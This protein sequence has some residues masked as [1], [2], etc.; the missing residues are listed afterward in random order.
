MTHMNAS[1]FDSID[2]VGFCCDECG[3]TL[4]YLF[5]NRV[6]E[7]KLETLANMFV[8]HRLDSCPTLDSPHMMAKELDDSSPEYV[9]KFLHD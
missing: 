1:V 6:R 4:M 9:S 3:R 5:A 7:V 2:G 8:A